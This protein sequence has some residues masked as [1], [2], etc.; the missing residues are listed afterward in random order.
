MSSASGEGALSCQRRNVVHNGL[1]D[2]TA[3]GFR[4]LD[5]DESVIVLAFSPVADSL[6]DVVHLHG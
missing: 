3:L 4:H 6:G 5:P 1:E 2:S